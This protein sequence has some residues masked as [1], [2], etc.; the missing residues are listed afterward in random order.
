MEHLHWLGHAS[1]KLTGEK[2]VYIDPYQLKKQ[3]HDADVVIITHEHFDHCSIDDLK[4]VIAPTTII[5]TT[6]DC[7]S[8]FRGM[9]IKNV[10]LVEPNQKYTVAGLSIETMPAYNIN[11]QFH[12]HDNAWIGVVVTINRKRIYHA[13]DTDKIPEMT[14]LK[15][16]D[17]A[18][19][20]VSGTYV[21]T[22]HEAAEAAKL[23]NPKL[24]IPMHWGSI[25]GTK[26]D[27]EE[28]KKQCVCPVEI[29][30]QEA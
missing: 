3:Y 26:K 29:L 23:F 15:N 25:V 27:A 24:A 22:A 8:K 21:M 18:L 20:P 14:T 11:K 17:A 5:V 12:P 10:Q 13:G 19:L 16:I 2:T 30:E 6:P 28:F 4:K 1:F 7:Q 9:T